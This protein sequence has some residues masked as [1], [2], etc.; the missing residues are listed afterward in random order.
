MFIFL[1]QRAIRSEPIVA[2]LTYAIFGADGKVERWVRECVASG[3]WTAAKA[4]GSPSLDL[5]KIIA[6]QYEKLGQDNVKEL[7]AGDHTHTSP[8][9][10]DLN[11]ASVVT[12]L[13]T[14]TEISLAAYLSRKETQ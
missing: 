3:P 6:D 7:F 8:K 12:G 1:K 5:T 4:D 11:A 2:S 13:K 9:G 10:A 14:L